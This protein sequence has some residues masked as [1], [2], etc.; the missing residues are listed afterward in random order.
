MEEKEDEI[1]H[2]EREIRKKN[3]IVKGV[4]DAEKGTEEIVHYMAM[5]KLKINFDKK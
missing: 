2:L 5:Q 3:I 4:G 1:E